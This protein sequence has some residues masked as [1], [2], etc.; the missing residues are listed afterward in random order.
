LS[1]ANDF[2]LVEMRNSNITNQAL[3]GRIYAT[4]AITLGGP[5]AA[6]DS[7]LGLQYAALISLE[8]LVSISAPGLNK[9][10]GWRSLFQW[11]KWV[12]NQHPN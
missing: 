4:G 7:F 2:E 9:L 12:N 11:F 8:S 10:K 6:V 5:Y 3:S 1:V